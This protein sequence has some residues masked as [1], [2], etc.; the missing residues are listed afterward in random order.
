MRHISPK[1]KR[2]HLHVLLGASILAPFSMTAIAESVDEST[3]LP[4]LTVEGNALYIM[5]SSEETKGYGVQSATV[6]TKAPAALRDIPQSITVLT[7]DYIEDQGVTHLDDIAKLTPGLRTLSNDSGRSS[8]FSRGYE[9]DEFN[10]NGLPSTMQSI[11]GTLPSLVAFDRVEILRGPSGLFNSAS[12]LGGTINLVRKQAT[13]DTKGSVSAGYGSWGRNLVNADLSGSLNEDET[14]R[15]RVVISQEETPTEVDQ[16]ANK[17]QT[18]YATVDI[19]VNDETELSVGL[20]YQNKNITPSN[21][22]PT[23][24]S[25]TL[26]DWDSTTFL[27]ANW[28][29]FN[30]E[31]TDVFVDLNHDFDNGGLGKLSLRTSDRATD[32]YYAFTGAALA[33]DGTTSLRTTQRDFEQQTLAFDASYSQ[34]F[35]TFSSISEFV[36]GI[37]HKHYETEYRSGASKLGSINVNTFD[38]GSVAYSNPTYSARVKSDEK[39]TGVYGKVTFRPQENLA[40]IAGGRFSWYDL[41][42]TSTTLSSNTTTPSEFDENGRFM[43]YA[44]TVVDL[45]EKHSFYASY[46][47]VYKPQTDLDESGNMIDAREGDQYEMG[48]KGSYN[49]G[50]LNARLTLFQLTDKNR[51]ASVTGESY[52]EATGKTRVSGAEAELSGQLGALELITG[53]AYM[54]T[55]NLAGDENTLFMMMPNHTVNLWG[56]YTIEN[57]M[58]SGTAVGVGVT[59]MSKFYLERRGT[60]IKAPSYEVVDASISKDVTENLT[61]SFKANNLFDKKYYSRVGSVA[62]FNFY[63]PSRNVLAKA[64]YRF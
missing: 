53:Y 17:D 4:T 64:T 10:I 6:G 27:G 3:R 35:E 42:A 38:S 28:N 44:G 37:D 1:S 62:T 33:D 23:D 18:L 40:L 22:F 36:V 25:G 52:Y 56:K 13:Y 63:G 55:E 61:L 8:I 2:N 43:P 21:G 34:P 57:G 39:E 20:L 47:E 19:D 58:L 12:E 59:A 48:V 41:S 29:D 32:Y 30:S 60:K 31:S 51:A 49:N 45:D 24:S 5:P 15:S 11:N 7:N 14:I 16:S 46:S 26:L 9:Y 50:N 54:D